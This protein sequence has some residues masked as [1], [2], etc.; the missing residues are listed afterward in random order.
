MVQASSLPLHHKAARFAGPSYERY[1]LVRYK[2][3]KKEWEG[4]LRIEAWTEE[5]D[6]EEQRKLQ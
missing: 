6:R 4:R 1:D 3:V 5:D 2:V